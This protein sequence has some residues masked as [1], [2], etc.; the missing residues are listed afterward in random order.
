MRVAKAWYLLYFASLS[1]L[2]PFINLLFRR[3]GMSERRVGVLGAVRPFVGL[4]AG[5]LWSAAADTSRRHRAVLLLTLCA[6]V[7][8]RLSLTVAG[9]L[10]FG[11]LLAV[12]A[13]SEFF[14]APVTIIVDAA[15]MA[16]CAERGD[17]GR[18]RL[19]GA[20]GWGVM[21]AVSG[22]AI[23]HAGITAAFAGHAVLAAAVLLPTSRLPFGPLHAKLAAQAGSHGHGGSDGAKGALE[24]QLG[25]SNAKPLTQQ[26]QQQ[27]QQQ[28]G[29]VSC[30]SPEPLSSCSNQGTEA[31]HVD[32]ALEKQ[33][34]LLACSPADT[35]PSHPA[36][37]L[38]TPPPT[39]PTAATTVPVAAAATFPPSPPPVQYWRGLGQLLGSPEAL[40]FLAM[41][42][43]MGYAVGTI[44]SWLFLW[45]DELGG[46]ELLMGL[47][48]SVTCVSETLVF[49]YLPSILRIGIRRCLHLVFAAFLLRMGCY[50]A[51]RYAP[52][53]W[54]V[55]PA[56]VLHGITFATAWG[57]GCAYCQ[58]L[59]PPGLEATTQ[60]LFQGL[61]FGLGTG[62]GSLCGGYVYQRH[63]AQAVYI[64]SCAVVLVGWSLCALAQVAVS[65][66]GP[67]Q[68]HTRRLGP[69]YV[70][71][72]GGDLEMNE[73]T[74]EEPKIIEAC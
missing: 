23:S 57:A 35:N 67:D 48:L 72:A 61:Y 26:Q 34:L 41:A 8:A 15:V 53:P 2:F 11:A 60:G 70:P 13:T 64:A 16:E 20:V 44:E 62:I 52:S 50:A 68:T 65:W 5:W 10:G 21:A 18:Q 1:C 30:A 28:A 39:A 33:A 43:V 24:E 27:Q 32:E 37:A 71:V 14:A 66:L 9:R 51:L 40:I 7:L 58:Q 74:I 56:E 19:W 3:L 59:S 55:L 38:G 42:T 45:L 73:R 63:G 12:V 4:P 46:S 25:R 31:L 6:S 47:S 22:T 17:Y 36:A 29:G 54:L 49:Y 69:E